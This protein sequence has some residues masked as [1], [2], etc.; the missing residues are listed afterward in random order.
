MKAKVF[1]NDECSLCSIE[2][3]H[4]K[5]KCNSIEWKG[6]HKDSNAIKNINKSKKQLIRRLHVK[7]ND[8]LMIGV[9]AFIYIWDKI[10]AYK[11]LSKIVKFPLIYPIAFILYEF[12]SFL[13]YL[14]NYKQIDKISNDT[15]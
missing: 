14:K 12:L 3:N 9:D 10:P 15:K 7:E 1:Y 13:L 4:Y 6:I 2:I 11:F 8:E 5:N